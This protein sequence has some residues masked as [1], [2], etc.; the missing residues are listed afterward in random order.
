MTK[1]TQTLTALSL[2]TVLVG[3]GTDSA[4][5]VDLTQVLS[6]SVGGAAWTFV[7]GETNAFLSE[8]ED[9]FFAELYPTAYTACGF[10]APS[11]DHL[12]VSVP[13]TP[14]DYPMGTSRNMT[15]VVGDSQNLISFDGR[16]IVETVT[17]TTVT[18][19]LVGSYNSANEV[20]GTFSLTICAE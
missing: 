9:D 3:C 5:D 4:A 16:I 14:G 20:N 8:G 10:S 18:G 19:G 15:F 17:A 11:G 1:L 2:A 12:L 7:A 6:G 13:K